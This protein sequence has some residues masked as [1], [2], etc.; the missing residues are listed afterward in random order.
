MQIRIL[1]EDAP[2]AH[3]VFETYLGHLDA[4]KDHTT[5][6]PSVD[7]PEKLLVIM[8]DYDYKI[9]VVRDIMRQLEEGSRVRA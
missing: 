4:A 9:R 1:E 7:D 6:C 5:T 2:V 3:E 8:A